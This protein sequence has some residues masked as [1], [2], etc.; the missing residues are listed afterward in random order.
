MISIMQI[1]LH[2]ERPGEVL[3]KVYLGM[4]N[5]QTILATQTFIEKKIFVCGWQG[6]VEDIF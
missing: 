2:N 4:I 1:D 6:S 3:V 5:L